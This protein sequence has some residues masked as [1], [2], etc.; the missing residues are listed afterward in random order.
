MF[1]ADLKRW[2]LLIAN[3]FAMSNPKRSLDDITLASQQ[4][5]DR[6][7]FCLMLET[8]PADR[9]QQARPRLRTYEVL[10]GRTN[11]TFSEVIR[12]SRLHRD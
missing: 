4:L 12:E 3:G 6:F 7:I 10:Y 2:R 5:L 1:L 9:I 11:K 8:Q